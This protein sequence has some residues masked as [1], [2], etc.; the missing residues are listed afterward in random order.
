MIHGLAKWIGGI[1]QVFLGYEPHLI[2]AKSKV[3]KSPNL[4]FLT[5]TPHLSPPLLYAPSNSKTKMNLI[6]G[7]TTYTIVAGTALGRQDKGEHHD[8]SSSWRSTLITHRVS[9]IICLIV[10]TM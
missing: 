1:Q 6:S 5:T 4:A 7:G 9:P 2:R 10:D 3:L 8:S